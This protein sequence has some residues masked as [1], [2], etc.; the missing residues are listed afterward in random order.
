M[1]YG[2]GA[3]PMGVACHSS[4]P[5]KNLPSDDNAQ[6]TLPCV[7][8]VKVGM[9]FMVSA[10]NVSE[11]IT[12]HRYRAAPERQKDGSLLQMPLRNSNKNGYY[13]GYSSIFN[14]SFTDT[15]G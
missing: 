8:Q 14:G 1:L 7:A 11:Q 3:V 10:C 15:F 4:T 12:C 2:A 13:R 6:S 9:C 5:L